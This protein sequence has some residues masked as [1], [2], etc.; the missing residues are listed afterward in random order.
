MIFARFPDGVLVPPAVWR[1][2]VEEG[3]DRP[4]AQEVST[5]KWISMGEIK[6]KA[7]VQ[8]LKTG[9]DDGESEAIG[10]V[11]E[12]KA[13]VVLLDERAARDAAKGLGF[14]VLGTIGLLIWAKRT[15]RVTNL[16]QLL[17]SL[18]YEANFRIGKAVYAT[19][20]READ[21]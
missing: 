6:D 2:V 18:Q 4:G 17:D 21:E 3:R 20:L 9:L 19:A 5:A 15:G 14:K 12:I 10:L 11:R 8:Y 13:D 7:F 1:E 16:R